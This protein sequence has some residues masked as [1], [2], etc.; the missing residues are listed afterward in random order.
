MVATMRILGWKAEGLRC[1]DHEIDCSNA[2]GDPLGITLI[3]MPNGTGKT[4]TLSLLRAALSGS[5]AK[6]TWD[7]ARIKEFQ[8]KDSDE[9]GGTFELRLAL[10]GKRV[11]IIMEFDFEYGR[12]YYKTTRGH[13]QVEGF[14][15]PIEFKRFMNEDFVHFYVFDGE[16]A[17][18]L[19][20]KDHTD[21]EKAVESLFQVH[22]LRRMGS[23]ISDYWDDRTS[24]VTAKDQTGYTRRKNRLDKWRARRTELETQKAA[25]ESDLKGVL[26]DLE[27]QRE[28]YDK[29]IQKEKDRSQRMEKAKA[30]VSQ[31]KNNVHESAQAVLDA[32]R[33][34][35]AMCSVFADAMYDLKSGLDR[36]KLPESAA[37]EFFEELAEEDECICGRPIDAEI[38]GVI[39]QRAHHYLG[40]DD[41]SLL[42]SMKTAIAD[43]VG[44]S[45]TE[46]ANALSKD[47]GTLS[48]LMAEER[49]AQNEL[50][51]LM[52]EAEN[53][54][55]EVMKA[56]EDI[57]RLEASEKTLKE[58]LK[59]FE[60]KDEKVRF[61]RIGNVDPDRITSV[62][63]IREGIEILEVQVAEVTDTLTL[64][65]KRDKLKRIVHKAHA[66]ARESIT[67]E[68]RTD[69]NQRI[70]ALM[71]HNSI[72]I[73]AIDHCLVLRGQSS[74][75]AGENLS[76][77]YAFLATLFN[78]ADEHQLPFVVDSPANPIDYDIRPKIG[79]LAPALTDQFIAFVISSEREKFL[80]SL[81]KASNK[82]IKYVT[83]FRKGAGR[84]EAKALE[85]PACVTTGDGFKIVDE[86]FFSEFQLD[87]EEE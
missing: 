30:T 31:L 16:L 38:K 59:K 86:K 6:G 35:Q 60:G 53:S 48:G 18:N 68:I 36:V 55:P 19:L 1:P 74:G 80:P 2:Q 44:V 13:G 24:G 49:K 11:T 40:S 65:Q 77:G 63:T 17:D 83:L 85:N 81:Q 67:N 8:K 45:R 84:H 52:H 42:N 22:L 15:P 34:P 71:P 70:E 39:R 7:R 41:V 10:N 3:Q 25:Y 62:E 9:P 76:I 27:R 54:D 33:D 28:R 75:S 5:A 64:R 56:R 66:K 57:E 50:D 14:D 4:T 69:A 61:D 20:D 79:Q 37:R 51:E 72:R 23:K 87:S 78:R 47:L 29:E 46:P 26:K 58:D 43:A 32:M 82:E 12:V 73:D 21:A